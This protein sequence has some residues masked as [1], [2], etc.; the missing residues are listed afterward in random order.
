[1]NKWLENGADWFDTDGNIIHAHGGHILHKNGYYYWYGENRADDNYVSCYRSNDLMNWEFRNNVL[2]ANSA[3][4]R[5]RT[6]TNLMVFDKNEQRKVNIERPKV[7]YNSMINKYVMWAH[8]ENGRDYKCAACAIASCDTPDG[9]FI[10]HGSFNPFGY[11]ARDCTLY[12]DDSDAAYFIA[13]SRDNADIHVYRL[14]ED[15]MNVECVVHKLWQGEYRE[16]PALF[17]HDGKLF[18]FSS[19][20]T[21]WAP[22]QCKYASASHIENR[23]SML[24]NI[25][26]DTTYKSQPAFFLTLA[27]TKT[28]SYIYIGDRWGG[29]DYH[30][31]RYIFLPITFDENGLPIMNYYEKFQINVET[32]EFL[33]Q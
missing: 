16:A 27:G 7:L 6:R 20:C 21:G 30:A 8:Y 10:Y 4:Q 3:T 28:T 22:N 15:Y 23:W 33:T 9:D 29:R 26:D 2:T 17:E 11:M 12:K 18:M 1:M 13:A 5:I 24:T 14:T 31:S 25:S 19:Y 32:G